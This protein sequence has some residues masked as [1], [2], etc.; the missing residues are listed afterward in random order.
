M[1]DTGIGM[2]G[3]QQGKIF[4]SFVQADSSIT[5][6]YGGTGL[7]LRISQKLAELLGGEILLESALGEGSVFTVVLPVDAPG[8]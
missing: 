4:A 2:T 5:R 7:G 8:A 6:Q 3:P 1:S